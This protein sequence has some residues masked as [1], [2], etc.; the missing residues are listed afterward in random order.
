M[1]NGITTATIMIHLVCNG[2][3]D[4][5][6]YLCDGIVHDRICSK[7]V[8]ECRSPMYKG[9]FKEFPPVAGVGGACRSTRKGKGGEGVPDLSDMTSTGGCVYTGNWLDNL[10]SRHL[11]NKVI[12][13]LT[14][15]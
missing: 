11:L 1:N 3:K 14:A 13:G 2:R 4:G 5:F 10:D 7:W 6:P 8:F 12:R 9:R 15:L